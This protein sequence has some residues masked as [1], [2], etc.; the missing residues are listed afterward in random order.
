MKQKMIDLL[1]ENANSSI[2]RR[3][4]DVTFRALLIIHYAGIMPG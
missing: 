3:Q 2:I 1:L 4:C